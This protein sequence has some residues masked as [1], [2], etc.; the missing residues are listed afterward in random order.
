MS[1]KEKE[2]KQSAAAVSYT[3]LDVYKRQAEQSAKVLQIAV[4][5]FSL[6][7]QPGKLFLVHIS[8]PS[9]LRRPCADDP[10][11]RA[12]DALPFSDIIIHYRAHDC[13]LRYTRAVSYTHLQEVLLPQGIHDF[14]IRLD[15]GDLTY[16]SKKARRMLDAAGLQSCKI[17]A[18][19]SRDEYI[20]VSYTH[21]QPGP[22]PYAASP[23][24]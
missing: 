23:P 2:V 24:P 21:L 19:N 15:S 5:G 11:A 8:A 6:H 10:P 3:H 1:Q 9:R 12:F 13:I 4:E 7:C 20:T 22:P 16:L 17:V 18:S 14:A